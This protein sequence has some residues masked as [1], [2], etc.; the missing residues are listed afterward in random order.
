MDIPTPNFILDAIQSRCNHPFLGY[1]FRDEEYNNAIINWYE[2][3]HNWKIQPGWIEFCPGVVSGLNHIIR[4]YT[5]PDD[6][7]IIQPP[8]Y[9][10][11]F[12]TAENNGRKLVFNP[13]IENDGNYSINFDE[14]ETVA[15]GAKML[16]LSNPHNPVGRVWTRDELRR[17]GE[18]CVK[19][20]VLIVSDEIHSDLVY[21]PFEHI[22][23]A[24]IS[25]EFAQNTVTFGSS[26]KTFNIAGLSSGFVIIPNQE[27]MKRYKH[28][29][30]ASGAGMGNI[31]GNEALK[32]AFTKQG[33][34]W[35]NELLDYFTENINLV[36]S[37]LKQELPKVKFVKPQGTYLLW[38]D[39]RALGIEDSTLNKLL[40]NEAGLGFNAGNG[41]GTE[42]IGFQRINI[43]CPR[44]TVQLALD[45]LIDTFKNY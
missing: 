36:D 31:F 15:K 17:V 28:E 32:A 8:V 14:L 16:I 27:L 20:N 13:L 10:P 24:S 11:F 30:E 4:A 21:K 29:L 7:I 18:I 35:L 43:A 40:I 5:K 44:A 41:F 2:N 39:F 26:S 23:I 12:S 45:R 1:T 9:H 42:G 6:R 38:I 34:G 19:H 22:S 37:A 3:K 25:E 33:E